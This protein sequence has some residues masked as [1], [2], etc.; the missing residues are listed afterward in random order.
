M[1]MFLTTILVSSAA[2]FHV[3]LPIPTNRMPTF[4]KAERGDS[5]SAIEAAL[6][7][8]KNFGP[9]SCEARVAWDIVEEINASDNS[10]AYKGEDS[11][12]LKD[13]T[14]NKEMYDKYL[15]L[16]A[17]GDLQ[18]EY[19]DSIKGVTEQI[20]AVKLSAPAKPIELLRWDNPALEHALS[21]AKLATKK[22]GI[23][24]SEAKLAWEVVEDIASRDFSEALKGGLTDEECLIE[25]I[26]SCEAMEE[27]N[28]SLFL[29]KIK[30]EA[31][32][33]G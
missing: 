6:E 3:T 7:A 22:T 18:K 4:L 28:R 13:P 33:E 2:A 27:L 8:S 12:A 19:L 23:D 24:S 29:N 1:K 26:D 10:I 21:E 32:V 11:N 5:A 25:M 9:T 17:L 14:I 15:K 30:D 20:R 31:R 16:K